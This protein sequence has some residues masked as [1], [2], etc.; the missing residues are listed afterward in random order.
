MVTF[1]AFNGDTIIGVTPITTSGI[2]NFFDSFC[3]ETSKKLQYILWIH[4]L[5]LNE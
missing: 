2:I 3:F 4:L 5:T 1:L